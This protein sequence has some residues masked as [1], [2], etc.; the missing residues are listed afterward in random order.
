MG[1]Y[2][3]A[4][5]NLIPLVEQNDADVNPLRVLAANLDIDFGPR[6]AVAVALVLLAGSLLAAGVRAWKEWRPASVKDIAS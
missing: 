5:K 1:A 2:P 6:P 3:F 4:P